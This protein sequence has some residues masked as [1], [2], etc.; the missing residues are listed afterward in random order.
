[1]IMDCKPQEDDGCVFTIFNVFLLLRV[2]G[3][4]C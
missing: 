4:S 2:P 3:V 1:M